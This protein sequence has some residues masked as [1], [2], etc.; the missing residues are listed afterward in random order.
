MS[1]T[2]NDFY[3]RPTPSPFKIIGF[4]L[5]VIVVIVCWLGSWYTIDQTQRGVV[6]RNG[7][8]VA[9][10]EPGLHFK[11]PFLES[12]VKIP[13]TQQVSYWT[14]VNG[15]DSCADGYRYEM[16]AYSQDQQPADMRVTVTWHIPPADVEKVYSEYGSVENLEN[17]LVARRAPQELKTVFGK[18]NAVS[19]IQNRQQFNQEVLTAI[20]RDIKGPIQIDSVQVENIDFSDLYEK[21]V[22]AAMQARVEVQRLEQQKQQAEV[23]AKT[24]VIEA[25]AQ[26]DA[27]LAQAR[28]EAQ[29]TQIRGEAEASAI[30]ARGDALRDNPNLISLTQAERWNGQLPTTMIPGG[31]VPFIGTK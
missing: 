14:C 21:T 26:A 4:I 10:A 29:A 19:V 18:F 16:Q 30:K 5:F 20:E 8:M 31:A 2:T 6:L 12:V 17:R 9:T 22:E 25:Q 7:A 24:T 28:A 15:K 11:L 3:P 27:K 1:R 13:I 23:Q